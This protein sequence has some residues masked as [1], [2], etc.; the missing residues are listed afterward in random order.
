MNYICGKA[1]NL[2]INFYETKGEQNDKQ[3]GK[4]IFDMI[5]EKNNICDND[6]CKMEISKHFYYL[7]NSDF[8]RI[9]IS[10]ISKEDDEL[11]NIIIFLQTVLFHEITHFLVFHPFL[12]N[13]FNAIKIEIE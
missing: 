11:N 10:Y 5:S 6:K 2:A 12:L 1:K 4:F 9:K 8:S 3:F 7:Y 13:H